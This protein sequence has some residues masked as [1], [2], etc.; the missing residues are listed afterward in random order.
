MS[1][2]FGFLG[3]HLSPESVERFH[4]LHPKPILEF[5]SRTTYLA[6]G[7]LPETCLHG[8]FSD[9]QHGEGWT[10]C[11]LGMERKE[12]THR[13]LQAA[14]WQRLLALEHPPLQKLDGHFLAIRWKTNE[15]QCF[16]DQLGLR[17]LFIA[18]VNG[19]TV[20]STRLAWI[21]SLREHNEVDFAA[22]GPAWLTF[23]QIGCEAFLKDVHR[24]GPNGIAVITPT[25]TRMHSIPWRPDPNTGTAEFAD[26]LQTLLYPDTNT[27]RTI[28][29]GL[30]GGLD[31]RTLLAL[32]ASRNEGTFA[33]HVF[34]RPEDP[35]V[36]TSQSIAHNEKFTQSHFHEPLPEAATCMRMLR[37]Y[38]SQTQFIEPASTFLKLRYFP[39]LHTRGKVII[40]GGFGE[41]ARRQFLNRLLLKGKSA[42]LSGRPDRIYSFLHVQRPAIFTPEILQTMRQGVEEQI[43]SLWQVMPSIKDFGCENFLDLLAI[44]MRLANYYGFEQSRMDG[45]CVNYMPFAQPSL[46]NSLF[47]T[48]IH[49]RKNGRLFRQLIRRHFP[50]LCQYPLV[51]N[52][53]TYPFNFSPVP[54]WAWTNLKV[55]LGQKFIDTEAVDFLRLIA[56]EVQDL[57]HSASV[58]SFPAYDYPFIRN[59]VEKFYHGQTE[60]ASQVHWWLSFELW[61]TS[62]NAA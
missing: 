50:R 29:L 31:S 58:K 43:A 45:E 37:D 17:T 55:R 46:L 22:C 27:G 51:K 35:D 1:W 32:L 19:G 34:G 36:R 38:A 14:D 11:G 13:F 41:I 2:L 9:S 12:Q 10:V 25:S 8:S 42:L 53:V 40:D 15:A 24:L 4:S 62:V 33:L 39:Q 20:F 48:P 60:F 59:I 57:V 21:A 56:A 26:V 61:R 23:N 30:S 5:H 54:A 44:R 16:T 7:G 47:K 49:L 18:Q 3:Q 28:S 6:A 52:G